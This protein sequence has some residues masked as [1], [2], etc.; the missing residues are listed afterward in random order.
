MH[1]QCYP[2]HN[3]AN[4]NT[5]W[6]PESSRHKSHVFISWKP[7]KVFPWWSFPQ[8]VSPVLSYNCFFLCVFVWSFSFQAVTNYWFILFSDFQL[9]Q[10]CQSVQSVQSVQSIQSVQSVQ[11]ELFGTV[12][13]ILKILFKYLTISKCEIFCTDCTILKNF[14]TSNQFYKCT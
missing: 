12:C 1:T 9:I 10:L 7:M 5:I 6:P 11:G 14:S 8:A 4:Y 13:T 3:I 2:P